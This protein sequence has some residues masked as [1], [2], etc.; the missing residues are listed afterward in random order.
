[1]ISLEERERAEKIRS[2]LEASQT[3][4]RLS[5][6]AKTIALIVLPLKQLSIHWSMRFIYSAK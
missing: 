4:T 2:A 6:P 5:L 1:M 3:T